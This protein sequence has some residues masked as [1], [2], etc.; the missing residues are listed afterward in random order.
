MDGKGLDAFA[1]IGSISPQTKDPILASLLAS[2]TDLAA[3][4]AKNEGTRVKKLEE[5]W[6]ELE[7]EI[8]AGDSNA[9]LSKALKH[10]VE[11]QM[12]S[13]NHTAIVEDARVK[14]VITGADAAAR[15]AEAAGDWLTASELF[16]RLHTLLDESGIYKKDVERLSDR[17]GMLRL[18]VPKRLYDLRVEQSKIN[19]DKDPIP[20]F[21]ALGEDFN[22]KLKGIDETMVL[23]AIYTSSDK[24]VE[25]D[26]GTLARMVVGGLGAVRTMVTTHDLQAVFPRPLRDRGARAHGQVPRREDQ[27]ALRRERLHERVRP[28]HPLQEP[29]QHQ[30]ADHQAPPELPPPRV[31]QRRHGPARRVQRHHL[32]R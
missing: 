15:K 18:Y 12:L 4:R 16:F 22:A 24:H 9:S 17:L 14:K 8:D 31:R 26:E 7:K 27:Q 30:R 23:R 6:K 20:P 11:V 3:N 28:P 13:T 10:A 19:G 5:A 25:H 32:A 2:N 29:P 21:N 1:P